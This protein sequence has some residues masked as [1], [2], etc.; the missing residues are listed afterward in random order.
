MT[1]T[2]TLHD[3]APAAYRGVW[4]LDFYDG[5]VERRPLTPE[6]QR[7]NAAWA[8]AG[9]GLPLHVGRIVSKPIDRFQKENLVVTVGKHML[10]DRLYGLSGV[11][12]LTRT[13]VGTSN[14]AAAVGNTSLTGG[15]FKVFDS[16]PTRAALT[17][18][19]VTTFGTS[20]ANI[21]WAE[22]A[23]DNSTSIF[24]RVAPIG[25]FSKSTATSI[26]VTVQVTQA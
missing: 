1:N 2:L 25:P 8:A 6:Q 13:G 15:V 16:T 5:D 7:E 3:A 10:L 9:H 19:S 22:L 26:A 23:L 20:E 18:T 11:G 14:T 24:N 17:V 4:T 12:A 21:V